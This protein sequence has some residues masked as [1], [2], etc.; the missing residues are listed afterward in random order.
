MLPDKYEFW[1]DFSLPPKMA[2]WINDD[3]QAIAKTGK[4]LHFETRTDAMVFKTVIQNENIVVKTTKDIE[5][6][7][8][9]SETGS[10]PKIVFLHVGN[11]SNEK[12]NAI[13]ADKIPGRFQIGLKSF[14]YIY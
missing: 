13:V 12:L 14:K 3:F 5:N 9:Q 7:Q 10:P 1:I 8:S 4:V 2:L 11:I 6:K